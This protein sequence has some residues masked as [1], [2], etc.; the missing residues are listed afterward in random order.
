MNIRCV[1]S[2]LFIEPEI[3]IRESVNSHR[4]MTIGTITPIFGVPLVSRRVESK[5]TGTPAARQKNTT[6]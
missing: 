3:T 6:T 5:T 4:T 1:D 2:I